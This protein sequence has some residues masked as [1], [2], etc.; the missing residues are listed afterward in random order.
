VRLANQFAIESDRITVDGVE[1]TGYP[2][3]AR[4]YRI[5]GVPKTVVGESHE[6]V[7]AQPEPVLLQQVLEAAA[8][9]S[10][11]IVES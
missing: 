5:S 11:L 6:F 9:P 2:D 3:L 7:G 1:V 8:R 10:S 4:Q